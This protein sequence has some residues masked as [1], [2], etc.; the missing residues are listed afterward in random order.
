MAAPK[1]LGKP[2]RRKIPTAAVARRPKPVQATTARAAKFVANSNVASASTS[3]AKLRRALKKHVSKATML[4]AQVYGDDFKLEGTK[5]VKV[6]A[7]WKLQGERKAKFRV[8]AK[9]KTH[10]YG[11]AKNP[12]PPKAKRKRDV[13]LGRPLMETQFAEPS[14]LCGMLD[15][16]TGDEVKVATGEIAV[17]RQ[18][19]VDAWDDFSQLRATIKF[20]LTNETAAQMQYVYRTYE[21]AASKYWSKK[22]SFACACPFATDVAH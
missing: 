21:V 8:R 19:V 10:R 7:P 11:E 22:F 13:Q 14:M 17:C 2:L 4:H 3:Q 1:G 16:L 6:G 12:G 20:P 9:D 18:A 5:K 15:D